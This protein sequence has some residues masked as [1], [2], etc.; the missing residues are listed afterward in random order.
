LREQEAAHIINLSSVFG[1]VAPPEQRPYCASKIAVRGLPN[2]CGT[3]S[4]Y[5]RRVSAVHPGGIKTNIAR[6]SRVGEKTP[7]GFQ[8]AGRRIFRRVAKTSPGG[9]ADAIVK[10]IKAEIRAS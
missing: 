1:L 3:S 10:G 5:P 7:R 4:K 8:N 2:H 6:H 9:A